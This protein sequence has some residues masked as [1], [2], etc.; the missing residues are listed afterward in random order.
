MGLTGSDAPGPV[1]LQL[2]GRIETVEPCI[3]QGRSPIFEILC[4]PNILV[5]MLT[6]P[7]RCP[8]QATIRFKTLT[9]LPHSRSEIYASIE[10][11]WT[12]ILKHFA[13]WNVDDGSNGHIER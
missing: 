11:F 10:P 8:L 7:V 5:L 9:Y 1:P 13:N 4:E 3:T 12:Q 2:S 6:Y